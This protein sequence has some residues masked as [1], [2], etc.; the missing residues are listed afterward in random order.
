MGV[1]FDINSLCNC[2]D[3]VEIGIGETEWLTIGLNHT[4]DVSHLLSNTIKAMTYT[5]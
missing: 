2:E 1:F 4:W 3:G 5:G